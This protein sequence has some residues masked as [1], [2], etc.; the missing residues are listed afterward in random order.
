V[1]GGTAL[2]DNAQGA[3]TVTR[4]GTRPTRELLLVRLVG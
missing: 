4:L 1:L 2:Y 3:V